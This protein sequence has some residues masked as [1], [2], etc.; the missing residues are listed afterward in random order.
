MNLRRVIHGS[1]YVVA[2]AAFSSWV[3]AAKP[4]A[5]GLEVIGFSRNGQVLAFLQT[6]TGEGSGYGFAHVYF[7]DVPADAFAAPPIHVEESKE[8]MP[9]VASQQAM[10]AA[11][12]IL[13]KL[14]IEK[15]NRGKLLYSNPL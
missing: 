3:S 15:G 12:P 4:S 14:K 9:T 1:M 10:Q 13:R 7:I 11:E 2:A 6:G 5:D 8:L